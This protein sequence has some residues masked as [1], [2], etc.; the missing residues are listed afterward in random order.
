MLQPSSSSSSE[1]VTMSCL[2][3]MNTMYCKIIEVVWVEVYSRY[4]RVSC[5]VEE[6]LVW[7]V[8]HYN[9]LSQPVR[10]QSIVY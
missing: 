1:V 2:S 7:A 5:G 3:I 6:I 9:E 4:Y 10:E 8:P